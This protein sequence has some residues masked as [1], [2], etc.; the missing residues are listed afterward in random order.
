[1]IEAAIR[2]IRNARPRNVVVF[3]G[4]GV[5]A[6][7]GIPTFRGPGGLWRDFRPEELATPEAF[8]RDPK[9]VWEWYEWR[10][11]LIRNAKPNA[12]HEAIARLP[13]AVVVTQNVDN[14][15]A[16][17]GSLDVIELH[18]NIFRV[19]CTREQTTHVRD[20]PFAQ[21]P[22]S[23]DCGALLRP[24]VVWFG[25]ALPPHAV[26]RAVG[27]IRAA[28]LL[29]VI[30]TSGVV[31]PAAGFVSMHE[32]LSIEINPEASGVSSACKFAIA[33][34]AAVATPKLIEAILEA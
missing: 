34:R 7:S 9:L 14:L 19:R 23:C 6:D 5:S 16:R 12:A 29:L 22:P 1:M 20:E 25:E 27:A 13:D 33:E 17:A 2:A 21:V 18:G 15:H 8:R 28:D 31:Y 4:A 11:D 32:G 3:T 30:G 26:A 10:R 24:D